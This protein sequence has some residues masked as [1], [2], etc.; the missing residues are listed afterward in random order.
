MLYDTSILVAEAV[1]AVHWNF[2]EAGIGFDLLREGLD[3]VSDERV[4]CLI[5]KM[6]DLSTKVC[7]Y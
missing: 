4:D 7:D 3:L 6:V 5:A 1:Q 2:V